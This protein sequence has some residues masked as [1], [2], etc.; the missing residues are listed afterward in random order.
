M[1]S[2]Q[3]LISPFFFLTGTRLATHSEYLK[4]TMIWAS[5]NFFTSLSMIGSNT[6]FICLNFCLNGLA[7]SFNGIL[8]SMTLVSYVLRSLYV[9]ANKSANSLNNSIYS[10]LFSL[11]SLLDNLTNFGSRSVPIFH[12]A[13]LASSFEISPFTTTSFLSKILSKGTSHF[14]M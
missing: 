3:S 6:G 5:N 4:G 14:G 12:S 9:Q 2:T 7:S 11:D 13:T 10:S 1:K 8:C